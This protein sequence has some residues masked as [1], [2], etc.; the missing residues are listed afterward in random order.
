MRQRARS[1]GPKPPTSQARWRRELWLW[2]CAV[3]ARPQRQM[4]VAPISWLAI[5][6]VALVVALSWR[7]S[8]VQQWTWTALVSR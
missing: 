4:R 8:T 7:E 2:R 1:V 6:F 3:A 5:W